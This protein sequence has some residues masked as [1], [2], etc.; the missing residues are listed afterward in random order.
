MVA[1]AFIG[2]ALY[3]ADWQQHTKAT[4]A[5]VSIRR[6][7]RKSIRRRT[8]IQSHSLFDPH[9]FEKRKKKSAFKFQFLIKFFSTRV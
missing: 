3:I 7:K 1:A 5:A 8:D 2:I 6:M 9:N 4:Q